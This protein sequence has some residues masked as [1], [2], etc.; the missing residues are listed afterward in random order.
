MPRVPSPAQALEAHFVVH[1][2]RPALQAFQHVLRTE[3]P[4]RLKM[5][6]EEE[7]RPRAV[8]RLDRCE[9]IRHAIELTDQRFEQ[10]IALGSLR[11]DQRSLEPLPERGM[12]ER[13]VLPANDLL[14]AT[15]SPAR[16]PLTRVGLTRLGRAQ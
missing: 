9:L 14:D 2:E 16:P 5:L 11:S 15:T 6:P 10:L 8:A 13:A 4:E 3:I 1:G 7:L 12:R